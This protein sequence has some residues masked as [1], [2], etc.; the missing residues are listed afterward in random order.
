[1]VRTRT[2]TLRTATKRP[3]ISEGRERGRSARRL[4]EFG[5]GE[6]DGRVLDCM[7]GVPRLGDDQKVAVASF[8]LGGVAASRTR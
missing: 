1:M 7:E 6:Q 5:D 3:E 2:L 4:R 8:P